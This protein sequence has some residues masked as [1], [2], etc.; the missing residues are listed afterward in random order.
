M[1]T[2]E[3]PDT[4]SLD[5]L[6][7]AFTCRTCLNTDSR[8]LL[9]P[10][11][12]DHKA[13]G[14]S[15]YDLFDQ[16]LFLK[17]KI[18]ENDGFPANICSNCM[19]RLATVNA[20][21][22][23]CEKAQ[24]FLDRY[25]AVLPQEQLADCKKDPDEEYT[26]LEYLT[27]PNN[28]EVQL[29]TEAS[30]DELLCPVCNKAYKR[31]VH[32]ERHVESHNQKQLETTHSLSVSL[33]NSVGG[34]PEDVSSESLMLTKKA[35]CRFCGDTFASN[36]VLAAHTKESHPK[37]RPFSCPICK[38]AFQSISNRNN[39]LHLHN[40][41]NPFKCAHC[42]QT[43]KSKV[44]L[45]R[46]RKAIHTIGSHSCNQC[47]A[48]FTN[49]TKYEYH[50]KS[51]DPNKKY[52]CTYCTKSF[53]QQHHLLNHERTHTGK[54]PFLCNVC[55]KGF[56][57][58]PSFK[59]HLKIHEGIRTHVCSICS[60]AFV[61]R[62]SYIQHMAKHKNIRTFQCEQC[63][64]SFIQ[65][66]SLL[67]HLKGHSVDRLQRCEPCNTTF[68]S[69]KQLTDH[70]LKLHSERLMG[71]EEFGDSLKTEPEKPDVK[72]KNPTSFYK[73]MPYAC[74]LCSKSFRLPSSLTTHMKIHN[75]ERKYVCE[76]CGSTFKRAEHLRVHVNG[77]HLKRKP[78]SCEVCHKSFAQSGDRNVHM[79]RHTNEK[80]HQ[81]TYCGK[82]FRLAKALRAH[83]RL[84]T[85]EKPFLCVICSMTFI[86]YTALACHTQ[87]HQEEGQSRPLMIET[88]ATDPALATRALIP[89]TR[90][91]VF[92]D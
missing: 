69:S 14:K 62:S 80:P 71:Q 74:K 39:H 41:D 10:I 57:H 67:A 44:Y 61:Q 40:Q 82:A 78:Y 29:K 56:K 47:G 84:H 52:K 8:Q 36:E 3:Q 38:K 7:L 64:K 19:E 59:V 6:S 87:K 65:R 37:D 26:E 53:I 24:E 91:K 79:R 35:E 12:E 2:K 27:E 81:C 89:E 76:E 72:E 22:T 46:H 88:S 13:S 20:F 45:N 21:R 16:L 60:K 32:L 18:S 17:L 51:H 15:P 42:G 33:T 49:T 11:F 30:S 34:C 23:Q 28:D 83:V 63:G 90:S 4:I 9:I 48:T 5:Q 75:E 58:E 86:S 92:G 54:R 70:N 1:K 55:G 50:L 77:I 31:K 73:L 25:F 43:F 66:N 68:S 85:G